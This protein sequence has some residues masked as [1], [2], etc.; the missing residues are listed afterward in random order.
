MSSLSRRALVAVGVVGALICAGAAVH[1]LLWGESGG[2]FELWRIAVLLMAA[3]V[4][5]YAV[6]TLAGE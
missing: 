5:L 4:L 3:A 2:S 1:E 6:D